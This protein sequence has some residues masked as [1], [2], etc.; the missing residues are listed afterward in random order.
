MSVF[1]L[2]PTLSSYARQWL[3]AKVPEEWKRLF[4]EHRG[5]EGATSH[6]YRPIPSVTVEKDGISITLEN[7]YLEEEKLQFYASVSGAEEQKKHSCSYP[8]IS[9]RRAC[10]KTSPP[11]KT[12]R[13]IRYKSCKLYNV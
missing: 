12:S 1:L 7:I 3:S 8:E 13:G 11:S 9:R 5:I 6:D 2:S 4:V 10:A